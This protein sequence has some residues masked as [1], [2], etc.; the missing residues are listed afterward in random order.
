MTTFDIINP[1]FIKI[2]WLNYHKHIFACVVVLERQVDRNL[3]WQLRYPSIFS[4]D[5]GFG[6]MDILVN[7]ISMFVHQDTKL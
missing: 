6:Q 3:F 7:V 1:N 2:P 4:V 5:G